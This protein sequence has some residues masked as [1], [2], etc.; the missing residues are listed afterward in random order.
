[1]GLLAATCFAQRHGGSCVL[2]APSGT[3]NNMFLGCSGID[4]HTLCYCA[5]QWRPLINACCI[6][7]PVVDAALAVSGVQL[8]VQLL[9]VS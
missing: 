9:L 5:W 8:W 7:T 3:S 2:L 6:G 4:G 1:M